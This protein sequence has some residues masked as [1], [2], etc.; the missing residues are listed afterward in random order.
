VQILDVV[1]PETMP[2]ERLEAEITQLA[3]HL[4]AAECRWLLLIAEFDRRAGYEQWECRTCSRWL[5]WQ[6]G[7]DLRSARD[8]VRTARALETLPVITEAFAAGRLSY[9]KVRALTRVATP[10][11][12]AGLVMIAEHATAAQVERTVR[13][14]RGV[15][16]QDD[17][18][19]E[20]NAR[21]AARFL[22]YDWADDGSLEGRFKMTPEVGAVFLKA[23]ALMREHIPKDPV[24]ENGSAEPPQ[25]HAAT[26]IDALTMIVESFLEHGAA[27]RNGGDR[28]Q[29]V[30]NTD[31]E[32]LS[33]DAEGTCELANG[34]ALAPETVRRLACDASIVIV[35]SDGERH[36]IQVGDKAPAIPASTRRAV[37]RRDGGCRFPGCSARSFTNIHHL[38]HRAKGGNNDLRNLLELCWHHH[39]LVHEGGWNVRLDD[40]GNVLAIRPNGNVLRAPP[41]PPNTSAEH[42]GDVNR[43]HGITID[44]TTCIPR[45]HGDKLDLDHIVTG[46]L[47]LDHPERILGAMN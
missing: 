10:A 29:I 31:A 25:V 19:D 34:P 42:I 14:Y 22:Q 36:V 24:D 44:P 38:H 46:L 47:C 20:T 15:L 28:Y 6:C 16:S 33:G 37:H 18:L 45:C 1:M 2:L 43:A 41:P 4:A 26:N 27:T 35:N 30:I 8:R 11:N 17:E 23:I 5:N 13:T 21:H 7:L 39:R 3:G 9:S 40:R 32:V 12:E